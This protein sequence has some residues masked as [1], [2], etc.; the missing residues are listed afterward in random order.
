M[1]KRLEDTL[2]F[3]YALELETFAYKNFEKS[4]NKGKKLVSDI[5]NE[6]SICTDAITDAFYMPNKELE[7]KYSALSCAYSHMKRCERKLDIAVSNMLNII[8]HETRAKYDLIIEQLDINLA[9]WSNSIAKKIN[10]EDEIELRSSQISA[11]MPV[12]ETNY[13]EGVQQA[14]RETARKDV[15]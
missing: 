11:V 9:R 2:A 7:G 3:R 14:L 10:G 8:S 5:I 4:P 1:G 6:I 15:E 13:N 12:G